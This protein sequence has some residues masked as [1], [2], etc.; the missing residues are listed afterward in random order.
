MV[1]PRVHRNLPKIISYTS[2]VHTYIIIIIT[3]LQEKTLAANR[4]IVSDLTFPYRNLVVLVH[5]ES[6][7]T[8]SIHVH[9]SVYEEFP[10]KND[11]TFKTRRFLRKNRFAYMCVSHTADLLS[12]LPYTNALDDKEIT[13]FLML[14]QKGRT[15]NS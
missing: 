4:S 8:Q 10:Q 6:N 1:T 2:N 13:F 7:P 5:L 11:D 14:S 15:P 12:F 9:L 3:H